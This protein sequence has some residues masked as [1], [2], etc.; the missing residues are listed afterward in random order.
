MTSY[1][2]VQHPLSPLIEGAAEAR[3]PLW[4]YQPRP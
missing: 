1:L 4:W 3:S 2:F